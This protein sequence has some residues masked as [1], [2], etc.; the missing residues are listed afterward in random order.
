MGIANVVYDMPSQRAMVTL[1]NCAF[2]PS[3]WFCFYHAFVSGKRFDFVIDGLC[4]IATSTLSALHHFCTGHK[5]YMDY[6]LKE[7]GGFNRDVTRSLLRWD[8]IFA[9]FQ[10]GLAA[11]L[12]A[13]VREL[14]VKIPIYS[15]VFLLCVHGI[16]EVEHQ[17]IR[18][19]MGRSTLIGLSI[20]ISL[21]VV[22]IT[23]LMSRFV[24]YQ[25]RKLSLLSSSRPSWIK[26]L[27]CACCD[28][29]SCMNPYLMMLSI[30]F[31]LLALYASFE[32]TDR[33]ASGIE[34]A[35][36]TPHGFWH[37]F[38][39]L[40]SFF[41]CIYAFQFSERSRSLLLSYSSKK[42]KVSCVGS[43]IIDEMNNKAHE[44][45]DEKV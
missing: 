43:I 39:S 5:D 29:L 9:Y 36:S 24:K 2:L 22:R 17:G 34:T 21:I 33:I 37:I 6:C 15:I 12:L 11:L 18:T 38:I 41:T 44:C 26:I 40:S 35:Y 19:S 16:H 13:D 3:I 27:G 10:V 28:L 32:W 31:F 7:N 4:F 14:V 25:S 23:Y 42:R 30:I 8:F 20:A 1:T 45:D